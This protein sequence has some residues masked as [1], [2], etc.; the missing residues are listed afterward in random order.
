[1]LKM[2][3]QYYTDSFSHLVGMFGNRFKQLLTAYGEFQNS[4]AMWRDPNYVIFSLVD[5]A[6]EYQNATKIVKQQFRGDQLTPEQETKR[7][8]DVEK[9][10]GDVFFFWIAN[11][12]QWGLDPLTVIHKNVLKL[13]DRMARNVIRGDGD[14]R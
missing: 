13:N 11:C 9:E 5:E 4:V 14:N 1:M 6:M 10:L 8:E 12:H 2:D 7:L 3:T